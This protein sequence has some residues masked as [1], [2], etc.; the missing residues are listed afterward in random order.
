MKSNNLKFNK[1]NCQFWNKKERKEDVDVWLLLLFFFNEILWDKNL[2]WNEDEKKKEITEWIR[3]LEWM[4]QLIKYIDVY[5]EKRQNEK[6]VIDFILYL[7]PK[8][9]N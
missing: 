6:T 3:D 7:L 2:K 4:V 8:I 5:K 9:A 1:K